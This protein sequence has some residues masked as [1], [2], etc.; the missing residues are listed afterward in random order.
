MIR[1][2]LAGFTL[3][4]KT[5]AEKENAEENPPRFHSRIRYLSALV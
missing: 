2:E 3:I 1:E 5:P 4:G